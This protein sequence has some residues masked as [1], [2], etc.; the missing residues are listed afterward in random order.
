MAKQIKKTGKKGFLAGFWN[1][2]TKQKKKTPKTKIIKSGTRSPEEV[3]RWFENYV[4]QGSEDRDKGME[5]VAFALLRADYAKVPYDRIRPY[6]E[7]LA[8]E[9][10]AEFFP[11]LEKHKEQLKS[12]YAGLYNIPK[13]ASEKEYKKLGR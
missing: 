6:V 5:H 9:N 11:M 4:R 8:K 10:D 13:K 2:L 7:K 3:I 1:L 12:R